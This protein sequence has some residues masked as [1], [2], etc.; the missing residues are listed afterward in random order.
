MGEVRGGI[1][2]LYLLEDL[3][4]DPKHFAEFIPFNVVLISYGEAETKLT[5]DVGGRCLMI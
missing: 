3:F 2:T 4:E 5:K 1:K